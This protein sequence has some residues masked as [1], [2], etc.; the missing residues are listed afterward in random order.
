VEPRAGEAEPDLRIDTRAAERLFAA[1]QGPDPATQDNATGGATG[2][3]RT[4]ANFPR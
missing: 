2:E 4:V 1:G 3:D